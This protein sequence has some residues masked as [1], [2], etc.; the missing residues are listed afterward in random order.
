MVS[1]VLIGPIGASAAAPEG[2]QGN[3]TVVNDEASPV[4]VT[5]QDGPVAVTIENGGATIVE[6]RYVGSTT[7]TT[8]GGVGAATP[9]GA[10]IKGFA[11][12]HR[13]CA[14]EYGEVHPGARAAIGME[15]LT[16]PE[17]DVPGNSWIVASHLFASADTGSG[18]TWTPFDTETG[19]GAG[20]DQSTPSRAL[21]RAQCS[22]YT[23][24]IGAS[25]SAPY[26]TIDRQLGVD[27]CNQRYRVACAA[28]V[29]IP[30]GQ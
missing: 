22:G 16:A 17:V 13:M 1:A 30:V 18:G 19:R 21:A 8:K 23:N 14:I 4:P 20:L 25:R 9:S 24:Q 27:S 29:V 12:L 2:I 3:V 7:A 15:A 26:L 28:P 6:W 10:T 5:I 11:A